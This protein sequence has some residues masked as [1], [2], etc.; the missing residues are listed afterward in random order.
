MCCN[1]SGR[2]NHSTRARHGGTWAAARYSYW[3]RVVWRDSIVPLNANCCTIFFQQQPRHGIGFVFF[4]NL[5]VIN[6]FK[7]VH[8]H[9]ACRLTWYLVPGIPG[10]LLSSNGIKQCEELGSSMCGC[11]FWQLSR[12][13]LCITCN[14]VHMGLRFAW[15]MVRTSG[16]RFS[17]YFCI[18]FVIYG[19]ALVLSGKW[20]TGGPWYPAYFRSRRALWG[21]TS[22]EF[23]KVGGRQRRLRLKRLKEELGRAYDITI[24][25]IYRACRWYFEICR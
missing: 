9:D 19:L 12:T 3:Y 1:C 18:L 2:M 15:T 7:L 11:L 23:E 14:F 13:R 24:S 21:E 8:W 6:K 5:V 25:D 20:R 17:F 4:F 16:K 22:F 10:T